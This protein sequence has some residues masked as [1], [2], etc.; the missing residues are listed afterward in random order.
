[1][2]EL[3]KAD[4]GLLSEAYRRAM[5]LDHIIPVDPTLLTRAETFELKAT[6]SGKRITTAELSAARNAATPRAAKDF[7][8]FLAGG[9]ASLD[10]PLSFLGH[11]ADRIEEAKKMQRSIQQ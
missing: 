6:A 5:L 11:L 1:M 2:S 9:V 10:F 4:G 8:D 3:R 7:N